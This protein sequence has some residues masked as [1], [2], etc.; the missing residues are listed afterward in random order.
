E[1][2]AGWRWSDAERTSYQIAARRKLR[3]GQPIATV[4]RQVIHRPGSDG[5][6]ERC[7]LRLQQRQRRSNRQHLTDPAD[8]QWNIGRNDSL[9]VNLYAGSHMG[10]ESRNFHFQFV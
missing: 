2:L 6:A 1:V 5:L 7:V 10:F 3:Q 4:K 8:R 9:D